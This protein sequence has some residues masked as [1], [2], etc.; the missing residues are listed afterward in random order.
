MLIVTTR[1]DGTPETLRLTVQGC[2]IEIDVRPC[3]AEDYDEL[4]RR[5]Y[6]VEFAKDPDTKEMKRV[7]TLDKVRLFENRIDHAIVAF[8]GVGEAKDKP[9]PADRKHKLLLVRLNT[10]DDP[11]I[12]KVVFDRSA[13][14]AQERLEA[15][16]E[17]RKN[18]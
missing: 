18:S 15:E 16:E 5:S 11:P 2:E 10:G 17:A 6:I 14:L 3:Y 9:W 12:W 8:R 7:S 13:S 1:H 4:E